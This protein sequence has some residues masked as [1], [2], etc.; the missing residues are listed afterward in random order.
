MITARPRNDGESHDP[1]AS[2]IPHSV[3][4]QAVPLDPQHP[5]RF[6]DEAL[7]YLTQTHTAPASA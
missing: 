4:F 5:E 1:T 3:D 7:T 2:D 6:V